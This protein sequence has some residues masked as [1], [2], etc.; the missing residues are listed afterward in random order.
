[1]FENT[2]LGGPFPGIESSDD[3]HGNRR[4]VLGLLQGN[5]STPVYR[6]FQNATYIEFPKE[7]RPIKVAE[8][9]AWQEIGATALSDDQINSL[10]LYPDLLFISSFSELVSFRILIA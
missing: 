9:E 1:M 2:P 4:W 10:G 3:I 7:L 5:S 6:D 8:F